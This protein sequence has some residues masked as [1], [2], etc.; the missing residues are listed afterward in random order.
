MKKVNLLS[1]AIITAT[2]MVIAG[3]SSVDKKAALV[4]IDAAFAIH[5]NTN[6]LSSKLSWDEVKKSNW[7]VQ[8]SSRENDSFTQKILDDPG[9][10][11]MDTKGGFFVFA[12][13]EANGTGYVGFTG[14]IKDAAAFEAFNKKVSESKETATKGDLKTILFGD[15]GSVSWN[16]DK[17]LYLMESNFSP[18]NMGNMIDS[19]QVYQAPPKPDLTSVALRIFNYKKDSLLIDDDRFSALMKDDGDVHFWSNAES[20]SMDNPAFGALSLLRT[21]VYFRETVTAATLSFDKGKISVHSMTYSNKEMEEVMK[22]YS[23]DNINANYIE[24]IPSDNVIGVLAAN[25]KPEGLKQLL[26]LGGLDGLVNSFLG[27]YDLT[28]DQLVA[29][30]KGDLVLAVTDVGLRRKMVS[31][32]GGMDSLPITSPTADVILSM[33]VKDKAPFQKL[34]GVAEQLSGSGQLPPGFVFRIEN[35]LLVAGT[36][37]AMVDQYL[38]G[39]NKK[40][41]FISRITGHPMG[42]YL[43]INKLM[44]SFNEQVKDSGAAGI[45]QA[46]VDMWKDVIMTGGEFKNGGIVQ[47][48]EVNLVDQNTNSL[49][50]LNNY[51]DK[52]TSKIKRPF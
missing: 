30:S 34:A 52:L 35:D 23:G 4:P 51:V 50:Q 1:A 7:F 3:C 5:L 45:Y 38:K 16:A 6:S 36:N 49:Q 31:L 41:P 47:D 33:S 15:K 9:N 48:I 13:K 39:G 26:K 17:F 2:L 8:I 10:S 21:E 11:G 37:P 20:F 29:A 42:M 18:G 32:G 24:R 27:K 25:Y 40:F 12:R 19:M 22:K 43:D 46:S 28:L 14:F 44:T